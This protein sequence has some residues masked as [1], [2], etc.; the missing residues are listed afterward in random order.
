MGTVSCSILYS[1][2]MTKRISR[3]KPR[4]IRHAFIVLTL[5]LIATIGSAWWI[6]WRAPAPGMIHMGMAGVPGFPSGW[7]EPVPSDWTQTPKSTAFSV[8]GNVSL[9]LYNRAARVVIGQGSFDGVSSGPTGVAYHGGDPERALQ[10]VELGWPIHNFHRRGE[11]DTR[12]APSGALARLYIDGIPVPEIQSLGLK[13]N[14]RLPIRPFW[15]GLIA[16]VLI[17]AI[18][19]ELLWLLITLRSRLR[20]HK[21]VKHGLCLACGYEIEDQSVCPECGAARN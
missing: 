2:L 7:V 9:G 20:Y 12:T 15:G 3:R 11:E 19:I 5:A 6:E 4:L 14:R 21:R 8:Y 16:T 13:P 18:A 10:R 17:Y 1:D